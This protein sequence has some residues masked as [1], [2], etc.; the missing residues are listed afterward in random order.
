MKEITTNLIKFMFAGNCTFIVSDGQTNNSYKIFKKA[1]LPG[2]EKKIGVYQLYI[3]HGGKNIYC[4][5][6]KIQDRVM[7][8]RCNN[9]YGIEETDER[10]QMLLTFIKLRDDYTPLHL[11]HTGRC[12]HCGRLLTDEKS[13]DRGFGPDCWKLINNL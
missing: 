4:G 7:K 8:F 1:P 10:L 12:A 11:Y 6:F 2:E 5:Y 13:I 9:K 3:K